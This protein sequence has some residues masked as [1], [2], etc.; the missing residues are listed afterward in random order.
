MFAMAMRELRFNRSQHVASVIVAFLGSILGTM[1]IESEAILN[2]QAS[3]GGFFS[4]PFVPKLLGV[5]GIVFVAI[6]TFVAIT[7]TSNTFAI[8]LAGRAQRTALFRLLGATAK[9]LRGSV[10]MEG[11]IVGFIG[12]V[13]GVVV[14]VAVADATSASLI[15]TK[16]FLNLPMNLLSWTLVFPVIVGVG[17]TTIAARIGTR[18][19]TEVSPVEALGRVQ[20][21]SIEA[22]RG[23]VRRRRS[24]T[25]VLVIVGAVLLLAGVG[26]GAVS[27]VGLL[28][29]VPGG[30]LSFIGFISGASAFLPPILSFAGKLMGSSAASKLAAAN[31]MRYPTRSARSTLGLVIGITLVTMFGVAGQS[32]QTEASRIAGGLPQ[33]EQ[34]SVAAF[35]TLVLGV[36]GI[37]VAFSLL[38][39]AVGLVNSLSLNVIHRRREIG[40]LRALGFSRR[41]VRQMIFAESIQLTVTGTICGLVLGTIYGWAGALTAISSDGHVGGYFWLSFPW[42]LFVGLVI[43]AAVLASVASL[44]P[45]RRATRISPVQ[46]A[47]VD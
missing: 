43:A 26:V 11:A 36:I 4:H 42:W 22:V 21:P 6:A 33:G 23:A 19:I 44:V 16:V 7:V 39:A 10:A 25:A 27:P 37:L 35:L 30:A 2:S 13:I 45:T 32:Y 20:E 29:A 28:L 18:T 1:L 46:A 17:S 31:A 8:V 40:L 47:A 41:Q 5:L 9:S 24:L 12:S 34:N 38:I 14:G 15:A 3:G